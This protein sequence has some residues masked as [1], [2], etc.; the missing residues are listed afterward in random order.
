MVLCVIGSD[1][2]SFLPTM[3]A[4][5]DCPNV[6]DAYYEPSG[7]RLPGQARRLRH[8]E[9]CPPAEVIPGTRASPSVRTFDHLGTAL[10]PWRGNGEMGILQRNANSPL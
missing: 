6:D 2:F 1:S 3:L 9:G 7:A 8:G 5:G 4:R 10:G